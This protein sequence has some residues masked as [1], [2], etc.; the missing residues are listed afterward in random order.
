MPL[1]F[2]W[3]ASSLGSCGTFLDPSSSPGSS[4]KPFDVKSLL[5][6]TPTHQS[7]QQ[8]VRHSYPRCGCTFTDLHHHRSLHQEVRA[9]HSITS[10]QQQHCL[11]RQLP[12][13]N[14]FN[15]RLQASQSHQTHS[16]THTSQPSSMPFKGK[17]PSQAAG[18]NCGLKCLFAAAAALLLLALG[19]ISRI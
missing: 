17:T 18:T 14:H 13:S 10:P 3:S 16:L 15:R 5:R 19:F 1:V 4:G 11:L 2:Q 6:P 12:P 9:S 8:A 7:F